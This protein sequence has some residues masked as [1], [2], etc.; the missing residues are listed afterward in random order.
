MIEFNS[1]EFGGKQSHLMIQ[2]GNNVARLHVITNY[3]ASFLLE[4]MYVLHHDV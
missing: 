2:S 4:Y 3:P 1:I